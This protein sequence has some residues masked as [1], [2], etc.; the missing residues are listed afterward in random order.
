MHL[1]P[2]RKKHLG[3]LETAYNTLEN[4]GLTYD[5]S[6]DVGGWQFW[7]GPRARENSIAGLGWGSSSLLL[8]LQD[9]GVTGGAPGISGR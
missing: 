8:R 3:I 6:G 4:S 7:L 2:L 1:P 5:L 9:V